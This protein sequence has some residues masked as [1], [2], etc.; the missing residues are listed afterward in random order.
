MPGGGVFHEIHVRI[1]AWVCRKIQ[2]SAHAPIRQETKA[3]V[4]PDPTSGIGRA[5][6]IGRGRA[7]KDKR[8]P[9]DALFAQPP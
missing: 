9:L 3:K 4:P 8:A 7:Q 5:R 6:K 1:Q 2:A